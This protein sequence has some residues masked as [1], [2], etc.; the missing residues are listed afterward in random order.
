MKAGIE[1][2]SLDC[3][4]DDKMELVEADFGLIGFAVILKL[5]QRIYGEEGYYCKWNSKVAKL[6]AKKIGASGNVVSEIVQSA[7]KEEVFDKTIFDK[8][9][10]LTSHG[11]QKRYLEGTK[12]RKQVK[13]EKEYLLLSADEITENVYIFSKNAN[14]FPENADNSKQ[15][16]VH[17]SKVQDSK[18]TVIADATSA[19]PTAAVNRDMLVRLFGETNVCTYELRF[20]SWKAKKGGKVKGDKYATILKMMKEDGVKKQKSN[21]SFDIN[22]IMEKINGHRG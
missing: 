17:D 3:Q 18:V 13:M 22:D 16:K 2:F 1:F 5:L 12:R 9:S 11:I 8:F 20:E 4:L 14:N 19:V 10:I 6:F 7:L 21:S 15:S